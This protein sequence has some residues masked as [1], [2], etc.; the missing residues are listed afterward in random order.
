VTRSIVSLNQFNTFSSYYIILFYYGI[1]FE[2][3][4]GLQVLLF[5]AYVCCTTTEIKIFS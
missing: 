2:I 5:K 4:T 1:K 3:D